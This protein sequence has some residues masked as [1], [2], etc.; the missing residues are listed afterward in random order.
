[1]PKKSNFEMVSTDG[2][3]EEDHK[4]YLAESTQRHLDRTFF[5]RAL[6]PSPFHWHFQQASNALADGLFLPGMSGLLNG[7]EASLRTVCCR[8]KDHSLAGDLGRVMS[9]P[10]LKEA[11]EVGLKIE[12]LAFPGEG[13]FLEKI[14]RPKDPVRLVALRNDVCHGN[15]QAYVRN[16][17]EIGEFFTPE[18]LGPVSAELLG[19][20]YK[21]ALEVSRFMEQQGWGVA[22]AGLQ[23]PK[24]PLSQWLS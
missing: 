21:W 10:L 17:P 14:N 5:L 16:L 19:V 7:I 9:N 15:F 8:V 24:N 13:G 18:C 20:S 4:A 11:Q 2:W 6:A 22:K 1:M 12:N 3:T 23:T